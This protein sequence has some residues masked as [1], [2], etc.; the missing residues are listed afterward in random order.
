MSGNRAHSIKPSCSFGIA[1]VVGIRIDIVGVDLTFL[2]NNKLNSG[3]LYPV[4]GDEA[5]I[6]LDDGVIKTLD[7]LKT[8]RKRFGCS[9]AH[10]TKSITNLADVRWTEL[11]P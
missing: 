3:N 11:K 9:F 2:I 8:W 10:R 7:D 6:T 1:V 4:V 5:L